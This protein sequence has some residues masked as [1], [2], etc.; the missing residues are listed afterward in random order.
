MLLADGI[1][2]PIA[3]ALGLGF[4]VPLT[5]LVSTIESL[6]FRRALGTTVRA[7]LP[8]VIG[9]NVLSTLAAFPMVLLQNLIVYWTGIAESAPALVRGFRW[10]G[11]LLIL[12]YLAKSVLVEGLWL[13]RGHFLGR[14]QRG[15]G[16]VLR[17]VLLG[18]VASYLVVGP[19]FYFTYQPNVGHVETTFDT[20][21]T[22]NP[23]A[24]VYGIDRQTGFVR[25]MR[26]DGSAA[27]TLVPH[28]A[29][30]F[31]LNADVTVCVYEGAEGG[32]FV[33][34]VGAAEPIRV[35]ENDWSPPLMTASLSPDSRRLAYSVPA[36]KGVIRRSAD[37][38]DTIKVFDLQS[39]ATSVIGTLPGCDRIRAVAWSADG[40]R[41][42]VRCME[43]AE[44]APVYAMDPD[45]QD[46]VFEKL[47]GPVAQGLLVV[48]YLRARNERWA[49]TQQ[50]STGTYELTVWAYN[51]IQV[52]RDGE[53]IP[54]LAAPFRFRS[55][56]LH[57]IDALFLP[58]GDEI[59]LECT[60]QCYLLGLEPPRLGLVPNVSH[61]VL[62]RPEFRIDFEPRAN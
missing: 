8:R 62:P 21:W 10:V 41:V 31:L 7:V 33:Q 17:A 23:D 50:G 52:R 49:L 44:P 39:R 54:L 3:L 61:M 20:N 2:L 42:F 4:F 27:H 11:P 25:S 43:G 53:I 6:V 51:T 45:R 9:A 55:G 48:N 12:M 46:G 19:L 16:G 5:L 28:P 30:S 58:S 59:L 22:R 15:A 18:N 60:D 1:D 26:V 13:T 14:I 57:V 24:V 56:A 29:A 36:P 40:K 37:D 47:S 35:P 34:Q 38:Q 32:L